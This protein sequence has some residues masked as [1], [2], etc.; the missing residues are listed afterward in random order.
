MSVIRAPRSCENLVVANAQGFDGED[1]G[2][3]FMC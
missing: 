2:D 3:L 1:L